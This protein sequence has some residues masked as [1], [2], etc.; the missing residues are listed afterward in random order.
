MLI[1]KIDLPK[2]VLECL[3]E[4]V[5]NYWIQLSSFDIV[6]TL[7]WLDIEVQSIVGSLPFLG[8]ARCLASLSLWSFFVGQLLF[9][10]RR[11]LVLIR[12]LLL[13]LVGDLTTT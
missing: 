2:L 3:K 10:V 6:I 13:L 11:L 5:S 7:S 12:L 4:P 1:R 8:S 9:L